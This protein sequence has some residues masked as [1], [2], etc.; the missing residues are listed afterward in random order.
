MD[1]KLTLSLESFRAFAKAE[2]IRIKPL[3]LL[4]GENSTGKTSFLAALRFAL[5]LSDREK[6]GYFN[7]YPF[8]LGS[9]EDIAYD[10]GP[11]I[12]SKTF[13]ITMEK[14]IDINEEATVFLSGKGERDVVRAKLRVYFVSNYGEVA[15]NSFRFSFDDYVVTYDRSSERS[16]AVSIKGKALL[17]DKLESSSPRARRELKNSDLR[18]LSYALIEELLEFGRSKLSTKD[19]EIRRRIA[20]AFEAF[21]N[22]GYAIHSSPPV[23]SIP[24]RVYTASDDLSGNEV[25]HAPYELNRVK[26]ADT[27]RWA[28]LNSGL[29]KYGKLAGLFSRFDVTKLTPQDSGPFQLK[30]KVRGRSS[31]IADVGYGVSQALPIMTDLVEARDGRNAFLFQQPEVHLHPRAQAAVGSIFADYITSHGDALIVAETHSD[32]L[33]DRLRIAAR[34]GKLDPSKVAILYFDPAGSNIKISQIGM[35]KSGNIVGA[36]SSYRE[37]FIHEQEKVLGF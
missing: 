16:F 24:K 27:R 22:P 20:Q 2:D 10:A 11:K 34:E 28:R 31:N 1:P 30:V 4:V 19:F 9:F 12:P 29:T 17:K 32:Y 33:I 13:S 3:T 7:V 5:S 14:E 6:R 21:N 23:R 18:Q 15:I 8:D 36:P 26:R 25:P 35:D 37:F